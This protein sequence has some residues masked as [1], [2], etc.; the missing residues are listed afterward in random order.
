VEEAAPE[1]DRLQ[2]AVEKSL[3]QIVHIMDHSERNGNREASAIFGTQKVFLNDDAFLEVLRSRMREEKVNMEHILAREIEG[4]S[5][6]F[7]QVTDEALRSRFSDIEDV[8]HRLLRNL[9]GIEHVRA[10]P[11]R[12]LSEPVIFVAEKLLPSDMALLDFGN[13]LGVVMAE[14]SAVSHVSI[15]CRSLD[16]PA[17]VGVAEACDLIKSGEPLLLDG[18]QGK[19]VLHPEEEEVRLRSVPGKPTRRL[20]ASGAEAPPALTGR[21]RDGR[22]ILLQ[23]NAGS[24]KE[25]RRAVDLG[26]V[27]IGL[28]RTELYYMSL[29]Q[30]PTEAQEVAF[31]QSVL[32]EMKGK[33]VTLRLLDLGADKSLP[34]LDVRPEENPQLGCRGIRFLNRHPELL[35]HQLKC[36]LLAAQEGPVDILVPFI[37]RSEEVEA[38]RE[39]LQGLSFREGLPL[40]GI[41]VGLMVEVP[42]AALTLSDSIGDVDF[43]SLGTNDLVQYLFAVSREDPDL[44]EYREALHPGL[45]RLIQSVCDTA[46][47]SGKPVS[48]CGEMA[49]DPRCAP[50]LVGLGVTGL[51][52]APENL[53]GVCEALG[54]MTFAECRTL[55][56]AAVRMKRGSEVMRL[57]QEGPRSP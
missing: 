22:T 27:G 12:K 43:L 9:L 19:V 36:I 57:L 4:L 25:V 34:Y 21:T 17:I 56:Q 38:F 33:P 7:A 51:S 30:P 49:G 26:A 31:Y 14:G 24:L 18:D 35:D 39:R 53:A 55:T 13:I 41:K 3:Q 15:I 6:Q 16:I 47:A 45:L 5:R 46:A 23:A 32:R 52:M 29:G 40:V 1:I 10:N 28:L 8:Y 20:P 54:T 42:S 37:S 2:G 11:V 44:E 48:V 50:L